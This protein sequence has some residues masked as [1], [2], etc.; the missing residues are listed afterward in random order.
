MLQYVKGKIV[1]LLIIIAEHHNH[2]GKFDLLIASG[3]N[4]KNQSLLSYPKFQFTFSI[5]DKALVKI[6]KQLT[7]SNYV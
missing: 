1:P 3:T 6:I 4:N 2:Q 7:V 5:L